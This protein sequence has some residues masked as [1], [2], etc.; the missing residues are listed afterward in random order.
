MKH[1][2]I[3]AGVLMLAAPAWASDHG[4]V[5]GYAT[6]VNSQGKSAATPESSDATA[7]GEHSFRPARHV[8]TA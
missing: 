2:A 6:P 7:A 8:A 4:P 3:L 5:F 1:L